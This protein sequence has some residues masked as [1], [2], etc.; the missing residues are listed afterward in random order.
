MTTQTKQ[1]PSLLVPLVSSQTATACSWFCSS[2]VLG[3]VAAPGPRLCLCLLW[4][5]CW[6]SHLNPFCS[7]SDWSPRR[8][9]RPEDRILIWTTP[10]RWLN[11]GRETGHV[12]CSCFLPHFLRPSSALIHT[13]RMSTALAAETIP[14]RHLETMGMTLRSASAKLRY[15]SPSFTVRRSSMSCKFCNTGQRKW[16]KHC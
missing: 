2:G 6:W 4:V 13:L 5:C 14:S 3:L 15:V 16:N 9:N 7:D 10:R 1:A 8:G 12:S 11:P